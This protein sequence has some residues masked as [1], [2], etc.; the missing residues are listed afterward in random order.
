MLISLHVW[1]RDSG[2]IKDESMEAMESGVEPE[3]D[4]VIT[5]SAGKPCG[6]SGASG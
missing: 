1:R 2:S 6:L 3:K 4:I 5:M